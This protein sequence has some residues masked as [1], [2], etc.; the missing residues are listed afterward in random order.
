MV[1]ANEHA[2]APKTAS[3][4]CDCELQ[5]VPCCSR[6]AKPGLGRFIAISLSNMGNAEFIR[7]RRMRPYEISRAGGIVWPRRL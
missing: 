6:L 1:A 7:C 4:V 3:R 2:I 5:A